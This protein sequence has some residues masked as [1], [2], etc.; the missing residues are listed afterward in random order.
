ML[1]NVCGLPPAFV[2]RCLHRCVVVVE[3]L[4]LHSPFAHLLIF[5]G[6]G[7][8]NGSAQCMGNFGLSPATTAI[9]QRCSTARLHSSAGI[10]FWCGPLPYQRMIF[11]IPNSWGARR[12]NFSGPCWKQNKPLE[13]PAAYF[14]DHFLCGAAHQVAAAATGRAE[15]RVL[16]FAISTS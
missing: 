5:H 3:L 14:F 4:Q 13:I 7:P 11:C 1:E 6:Y 12:H 8:F 10:M 16:V 15:A 9:R 2:V